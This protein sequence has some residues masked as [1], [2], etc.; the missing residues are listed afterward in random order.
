MN[1]VKKLILT[2]IKNGKIILRED[3]CLSPNEYSDILGELYKDGYITKPPT[4]SGV[5]ISMAGCAITEKG[6]LYIS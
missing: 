1:K 3:L 6:L 5:Y 4:A 2:K